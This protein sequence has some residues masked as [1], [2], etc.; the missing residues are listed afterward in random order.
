MVYQLGQEVFRDQPFSYVVKVDIRSSVCDFCLKE[1]KRNVKFKNC[2]A[3]KTVYYCNSKCQRNSWNSHHQSECV[4]LRKA[5]TFVLKNGFMLLLI[6]IILK[7]Q[8]E[9][10]FEGRRLISKLT[11]FITLGW[12]IIQSVG[13]TL[14]LKQ[15]LFNSL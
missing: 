10:D 14:C 6:R 11:R 8:K 4:Y 13:V 1:S 3:C 2:S 15:V 5:P 7:L 12:A 9:G